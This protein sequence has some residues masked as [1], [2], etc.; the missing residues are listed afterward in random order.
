[1]LAGKMAGNRRLRLQALL[2]I[3]VIL[4]IFYVTTAK[5]STYASPFYSRT[6]S[7][8]R[9]RQDAASVADHNAAEERRS[10]RVARLQVEH[11]KAMA[12]NAKGDT[13]K[14]KPVIAEVKEK[15]QEVKA[16]VLGEDVKPVTGRKTMKDGRVVVDESGD[17]A[18]GVARVG[19]NVEPKEKET[20]TGKSKKQSEEE[21]KA[22]VEINSILKKGPIIIFSKSYCPYSKKAKVSVTNW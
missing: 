15:V 9:D 17:S 3:L 1:M 10:E 21:E 5:R 12:D 22:E 2:F 11:D 4:V 14:Q 13:Q 16:A 8:I 20:P 7:A 6:M 18:D 19:N